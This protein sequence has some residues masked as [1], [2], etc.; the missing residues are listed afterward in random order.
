MLERKPVLEIRNLA[1]DF[2]TETRRL[3]AVDGI[4]LKL[5]PGETHALLGESGSGKSVTAAA[6]LDLIDMPPGH[7][8]SGEILFC[9]ENILTM[10]PGR[11]RQLYG[12]DIAVVF[13]D[14]SV[15]LNPAYTVGQQ[16]AE[17]CIIHGV[18]R[19]EA[20]ERAHELLARVGIP[21]SRERFH[22]F[23]HQFSGGQRQ[24][25]M[26]AMAI[27][28]RPKLV[29][30][31]EPTTALDVTVQARILQLLRELQ[32]ETGMALLMITHDLGV[33]ADIAQNASVMRSGRIVES[34]PL[35]EVFRNPQHDY[36]HQLLNAR[37]G[38]R[39]SAA[40]IESG[41][42]L[43][44]EGLCVDYGELR[45]VDHVNLQVRKGEI[46]CV[47]GE[48]GS[49]KSTL[50]GAALRL[51]TI[52]EGSIRFQG[53]DIVKLKARQLNDYRKAVQAVFQDPF[54]SLNPR[55][56]IFDILSEPW[57]IQGSDFPKSEWR[58]RAAD[59]LRQVELPASD[60]DRFPTEFSGGQRQR[61][62]IARALA[63][64]SELIVCD[65][66]VSALDMSVQRQIVD[67]LRS[68]RARTG[69]ALLFITHDLGLVRDFA[70][71]VV[72]MKDG[73]VV[74]AGPTAQ[75][76]D[77]PQ[78][79]YTRMLMAASPA[80]D[81]DV[82]KERRAAFREL[83]TNGEKQARRTPASV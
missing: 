45:A 14:P 63:L 58:A 44:V 33:A 46:V 69:V 83:S 43:E 78:H 35:A 26:I 2:D 3:T 11:R 42:I 80:Q 8:R 62:A 50:A 12:R 34:G 9:G 55:L 54:G 31:D 24:R 23:P 41:V 73:K 75:V 57:V 76:F 36:T 10:P 39:Q 81:P 61:I 82:Q 4:D 59:L 19:N 32:E 22:Q 53:Q 71:R 60:L 15:H 37:A 28:M 27:A 13:Q 65:E 64:Q 56:S 5:F 79:L 40:P 52:A 30:A 7:L 25:I 74:E 49:G 66:A 47:V 6:I 51:R 70:D 77:A 16:I 21:R 72:V 20:R 17:V 29:I 18:A 38:S 1:V 68:L 48:S 67:L